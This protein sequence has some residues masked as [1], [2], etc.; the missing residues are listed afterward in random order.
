MN[1]QRKGMNKCPTE[2]KDYIFDIAGPLSKW[3]NGR[4]E[5]SS[6]FNKRLIRR[7]AILLQWRGDY[8]K[9]FSFDSDSIY[10]MEIADI[11]I[12][13]SDEFHLWLVNELER[14]PKTKA[15]VSK[16][17]QM[18]WVKPWKEVI[19]Y[20]D[21]SRLQLQFD[22]ALRYNRS[23][24]I[25]HMMT[26]EAL[27]KKLLNDKDDSHLIELLIECNLSVIDG[28]EDMLHK[29]AMS[30][31]LWSVLQRV[32]LSRSNR[33][34]DAAALIGDFEIAK[35]VQVNSRHCC[36]TWAMDYAAE[37]GHLEVVKCLHDNRTEGCTTWAMNRAA[38]EGHLEI[39]KWLHEN[40]T[41]G[42]TTRAMDYAAANG[43]LEVVKWLHENRSEGCTTEAMNYAAANGHLEVVKW[44][45]ENRRET[46]HH[47]D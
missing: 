2:L 10:R 11:V 33:A 7:E 41:E 42:C 14:S 5:L 29:K 43:H 46:P 13:K 12:N 19:D 32:D 40:R 37:N 26:D 36:T 44:L 24:M 28:N 31:T 9:L 34:M 17:R 18:R 45:R 1:D 4:M 27:R 39:V 3:L 16:V 25:E 6:N 47:I 21:S 20:S 35:W 38:Q 22:F 8:S 23:Y 30:Q 15:I